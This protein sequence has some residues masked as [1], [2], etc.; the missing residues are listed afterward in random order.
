EI[1]VTPLI[2]VL[3]VML[4]IFMVIVPVMPRGLN[5]ALPSPATP[6]VAEATDRP[7]LV[8]VE[9]GEMV[10]RYVVD[11]VSLERSEVAPRLVELLSRRSVRQVLVKGDTK[12]DFGVIA[13]VIDAGKAAGAQ[14]VGL[15]T[16][17]TETPSR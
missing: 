11:G 17:G 6:E 8:K 14:S 3:L 5:S 1:N 13:G 4:I 7:V 15:L 16:P 12:L 10:V 9:Q 2:D